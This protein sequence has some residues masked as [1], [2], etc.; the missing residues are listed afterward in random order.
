MTLSGLCQPGC[1]AFETTVPIN[2]PIDSP[3]G[4]EA[5]LPSD[6]SFDADLQPNTSHLLNNRQ[7]N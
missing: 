1:S 7:R 6:A 5:L 3:S 2:F 4:S